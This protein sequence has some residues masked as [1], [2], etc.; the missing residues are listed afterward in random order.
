MFKIL[1]G[2]LESF[3]ILERIQMCEYAHDPGKTMHL[4]NKK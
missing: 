1:L 3:I 4:V 2:A